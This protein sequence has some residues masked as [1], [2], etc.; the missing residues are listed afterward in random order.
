MLRPQPLHPNTLYWW[1]NH[2][3]SVSQPLQDEIDL[4]QE[5]EENHPNPVRA[6]VG[7]P[8]YSK[9]VASS[10]SAIER[11]SWYLNQAKAHFKEARDHH[12][13]YTV[14]YEE[15]E[16]ILEKIFFLKKDMRGG[17]LVFAASEQTPSETIHAFPIIRR[18]VILMTKISI[19]V[20]DKKEA[21]LLAGFLRWV[22][23]GEKDKKAAKLLELANRI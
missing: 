8:S 6:P 5:Q 12:G 14:I 4:T 10:V 19:N 3:G 11:A 17:Q 1:D 13:H 2:I 9:V 15:F 21:V 7:L 20:H 18:C 16:N 22:R 23:E